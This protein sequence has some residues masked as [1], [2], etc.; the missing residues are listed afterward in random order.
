MVWDIVKFNIELIR[1][2]I[3]GGN[4]SAPRL[5]SQTNYG[6]FYSISTDKEI[7]KILI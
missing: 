3:C 1:K 5:I 7:Y 2:G 4:L 6:A